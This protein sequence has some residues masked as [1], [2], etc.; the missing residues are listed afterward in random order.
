MRLTDNFSLK[1]LVEA[2]MPPMAIQWNNE[3]ITATE[4]ANLKRIAMVLQEIRNKV[5][6]KFIGRNGRQIGL[7]IT[8][9]YR[10]K[11]WELRQKRSGQSMHVQGLA[12]DFVP[13][14]CIDDRQYI[15]IYKWILFEYKNWNGGLA[16]MDYKFKKGSTTEL[17]TYGFIHI[18][19][20]TKRRW[21]Y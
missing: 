21:K 1:E 13:V 6:E 20:G 10:T 4:R 2:T 17:E 12:V 19:L 9:G 15:D 16:A 7:R 18:D 5:N 8:S 14:N 11:R 3:D